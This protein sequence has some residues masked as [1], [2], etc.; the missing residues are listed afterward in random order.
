MFLRRKH[1]RYEWHKILFN[2]TSR[3]KGAKTTCGYAGDNE[4]HYLDS[5][6][7]SPGYVLA[8]YV[9]TGAALFRGSR[10][11]RNKPIDAVDLAFAE[12]LSVGSECVCIKDTLARIPAYQ[13]LL[14]ST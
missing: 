4:H 14:R 2:G 8:D 1:V 10:E 11:E 3:A 5:P 13:V 12:S 6:S 9:I 7:S